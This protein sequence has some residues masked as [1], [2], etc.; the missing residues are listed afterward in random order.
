MQSEQ[1]FWLLAFLHVGHYNH[2][3]SLGSVRVE[4]TLASIHSSVAWHT[5]RALLHFRKVAVNGA[6]A[7]C[8]RS[9]LAEYANGSCTM[10][11]APKVNSPSC[12]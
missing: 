6:R 11:I 3:L 1:S 9:S 7:Q 8:S 12:L 10:F 5:S 4:L 2:D